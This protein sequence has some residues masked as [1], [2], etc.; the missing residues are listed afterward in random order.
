LT[1]GKKKYAEHEK[2]LTEILDETENIRS[3]LVSIIDRDTAAFNGVITAMAMPVDTDGLKTDRSNAM[4]MALKNCTLTPYE[5]MRC[6]LAALELAAQALGK[7]NSNV[8]SDLGVAALSLK[9]A[10][11]GAWLNILT[12]VRDIKDEGFAARYRGEGESILAR[13]LPLADYVYETV[14]SGIK[15]EN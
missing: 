10:V 7:I 3:R 2:L 4:Q 8:S 11:Q 13:A 6:A 1:I 9:A 5:M 12:N 14:L 15:T